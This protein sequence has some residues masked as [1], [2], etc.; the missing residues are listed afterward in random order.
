MSGELAILGKELLLLRVQTL[1]GRDKMRE[2]AFPCV[3]HRYIIS[4]S[5]A[6]IARYATEDVMF[7]LG[8]GGTHAEVDLVTPARKHGLW[9]LTVGSEL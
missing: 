9:A 3:S 4:V 2:S 1:Q 8:L 7:D 6:V 5:R